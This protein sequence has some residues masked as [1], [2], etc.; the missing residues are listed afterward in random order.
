MLSIT[1]IIL[2]KPDCQWRNSKN[3]KK[4]AYHVTF[5]LDL[6]N[7]LGGCRPTSTWWPS[8]ASLAAMKP[9]A[10][11]KQ[12]SCQHKSARITW[13]LTLTLSTPWMHADLESIL[14]KF[15]GDPAIC[16]REEAICAKV[17]RWMPRHCI[18]SF[19]E[20]AKKWS[21]HTVLLPSFLSP[22]CL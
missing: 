6:E 15:G 2:R 9:F 8:C 19:L 7:T 20:W 1:V 22:T 17:Y 14:W 11:E 10:R 3:P 4:C 12:F 21:S 16:V 13:P 5:D 18:C